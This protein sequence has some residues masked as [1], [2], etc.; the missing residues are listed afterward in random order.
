M[1]AKFQ[2]KYRIDSTR[3]QSW[4]YGSNGK[5]FITIC[6]CEME[7][8]FGRIADENMFLN[9]LGELADSY[10]REIPNHFPYVHLDEF[11]V[12]PNHIHGIL[13]IDD[14][15]NWKNVQTRQCLVSNKSYQNP[16]RKRFQNQGNNTISS[17]IGSYKSIVS[18]QAHKINPKFEWHTRFYDHIIKDQKALQRIRNYI[19]YNPKNWRE[20][21]YFE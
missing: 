1:S 6:T 13:V 7:H 10:W 15:Y 3:L 21:K 8:F 5:Y 14:P 20:D 18:R 2:N 17:I 11:I 4:D 9:E 19:K 16:G 12:M